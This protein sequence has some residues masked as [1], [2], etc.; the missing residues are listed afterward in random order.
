M[1]EILKSWLLS[2]FALLVVIALGY[3]A[4]SSIE[5]GSEHAVNQR[6]DDLESQNKDLQK[7]VDRLNRELAVYKPTKPEEPEES[8]PTVEPLPTSYKHQ[9]LISEL[10]KLIADNINMKVGSRG[11]R[12]G[13]VQNFL[14]LYNN[15]KNKVDNAYGEGTKKSVSLFQKNVGLSADGNAGPATYQ[16]MVEWL[17]T[18]G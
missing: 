1:I 4:F 10:E 3:W 14:N 7:E 17:K 13:T 5:S 16:K 9:T 11:T 6:I 12:V 15:T 2:L 8:E 18:Q